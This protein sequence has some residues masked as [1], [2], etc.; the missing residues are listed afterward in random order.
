MI[1]KVLILSLAVA[2]GVT[3]LGEKLQ[4]IGLSLPGEGEMPVID[5]DTGEL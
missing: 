3:V 5:K 4:V 2:G 1:R